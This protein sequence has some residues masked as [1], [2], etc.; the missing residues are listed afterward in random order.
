MV[1]VPVK[2]FANAKVRLAPALPP[3]ERAHLARVMAERVLLAAR[4]LP[5]TVVCD[6]AEVA[7]WARRRGAA[8]ISQPGKG[9]NRAVTEGVTQLGISGAERVTVVHADLPLAEDLTWPGRFGG[10]TLVPDRHRDGT[11]V[12]S[13]P[14]RCGFRFAYGPGSLDRHL[15]EA[16]RLGLPVRVVE[17]TSLSWDVDVPD[18]LDLPAE[19]SAGLPA[20]MRGRRRGA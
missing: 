17:E 1:L 8:V 4:P 13:I 20:G 15:H 18:D 2:A 10:V 14:A 12:A 11:N 3:A 7:S 6:D 16:R 19:L 5:V 9:L